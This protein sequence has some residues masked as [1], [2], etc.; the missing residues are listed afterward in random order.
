MVRR[1]GA[2]HSGLVEHLA[3]PA[4]KSRAIDPDQGSAD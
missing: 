4:Q 3:N 1:L 2:P